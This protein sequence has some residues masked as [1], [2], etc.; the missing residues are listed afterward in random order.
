MKIETLALHTGVETDP[1]T[2]ASSVP[3]YQ[4]STFHQTDWDTAPEFDYARSGNPTRKALEH[5]IAQLEGAKHGFA[6]ASGMA[7]ITGVLLTF[8]AGTHIVACEDIYGGTYRAL[9]R[10]FARLGI[11]TTF[12]DATDPASIAAAIR[13]NTKALLL[14]TP[15]NPTLQIIDLKKATELAKSRQLL[16]IVDNTFMTPYL[17]R[18]HELG[19]DVVIHSATKFL[20]GHSDV[21][22]GLVTVLNDDLARDIYLIQNGFGGILGP[23][24]CWLL[25]RGIKTLPL[26]MKQSQETASLIAGYLAE[27]PSVKKVYYPG[28]PT[29][30]GREVHLGQAKGPGAVLSFDLENG[31]RVRKFV[32]RLKLPLFAVSLGAVESIL[33]YPVKMSHASMPVEE[34]NKRG[35]TDGLLRLSAGLEDPEDLIADIEQALK[36]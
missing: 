8:S 16:T 26:R 22:A 36:G 1:H 20:G 27:H 23:Q 14:E 33:S 11:E 21:V 5:S 2:G 35:I 18:P 10:V 34:R 17:Q 30:P 3:I 19:I 28:L 24:D 7:A 6:F 32:E 15:S 25:M 13:P 31:E 4:A 29:H 12:V 9:T